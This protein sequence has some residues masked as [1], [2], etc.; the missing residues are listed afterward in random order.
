MAPDTPTA[1]FPPTDPEGRPVTPNVA[2]PL[3]ERLQE[4]ESLLKDAQVHLNPEGPLLA[5]VAAYFA[6]Y[7]Q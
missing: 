7:D 4:A 5:R 6:R 1:I 2:P 3:S